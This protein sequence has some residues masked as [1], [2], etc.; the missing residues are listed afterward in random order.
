VAKKKKK[1]PFPPL[2]GIEPH[3]LYKFTYGVYS[4][5]P[6]A[7]LLQQCLQGEW[8]LNTPGELILFVSGRWPD[9]A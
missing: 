1:R 3:S 2:P 9:V 7:L 8:N 6:V 5:R 4:S